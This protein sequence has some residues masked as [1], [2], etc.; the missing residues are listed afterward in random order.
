MFDSYDSYAITQ[1]IRPG[2][3]LGAIDVVHQNFEGHANLCVVDYDPPVPKWATVYKRITLED[4]EG[5]N[6]N[7]VRQLILEG[8]Q[9]IEENIS[10][11]GVVV[12]CA[13]GVSRS[14]TMVIAYL[15]KSEKL[16]YERAF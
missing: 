5:L 1:Q 8:V 10:K 4:D 13:M 7:K 3:Y 16:E 9:F 11:G 6:E 2:L 12:N 14:A 15:M